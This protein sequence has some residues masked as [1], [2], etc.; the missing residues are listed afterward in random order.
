MD[1]EQSDRT[2]DIREQ[3]EAFFVEHILPRDADWHREVKSAAIQTPV[4]HRA[5][6]QGL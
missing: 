1:F 5:S 3:V 6:C 2:R 4:S